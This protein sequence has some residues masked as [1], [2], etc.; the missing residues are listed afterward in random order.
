VAALVREARYRALIQSVPDT[1]LA[2]F[3]QRLR[4]VLA[5][6]AGID[7]HAPGLLPGTP[8]ADLVPPDARS[9]AEAHAREALAGITTTFEY[10]DTGSRRTWSVE[11]GPYRSDGDE[12]GVVWVARD[13]SASRAAEAELA[14]RALHDPLTGLANR[15]LFMDR[16]EQGLARL[17]RRK[18][19]VAVIFIDLDRLKAV[20]DS[21]GHVAGDEV[22]TSMARRMQRVLRPTDTLARFGGDEFVALC[23]EVESAGEAERIA[24]RLGATIAR[25]LVIEDR[26]LVITASMGI[27]LTSNPYTNPAA[28]LRDADAAMYRAKDRG[29]AT[30]AFYNPTMRLHAVD[31]LQIENDLRG[32]LA[33]G[34]LHLLY[35]PQVRMGDYRTIGAEALLRWRHPERG[36]I[37]PAG[38]IALAEETGLMVPIGYWVIEQVCRD[39]GGWPADVEAS[40]NLSANQLAD[41]NLVPRMIAILEQTGVDPCRLCLE[42]TENALFT[43]ADRAARALDELRGLGCRVAIDDFGVGFSSLYHLRQLPDI[44]VL[45]LDRAFVSELGHNDRDAAIVASVILLTN[46]LGMEAL[47][48]GVETEA[49][50]DHLRT[51]GCD[52]GQGFWFGTPGPVEDL[53]ERLAAEAGA[54]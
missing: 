40:I 11:V 28:L 31:R 17:T 35:Q 36:V 41:E 53:T 38:F 33:G 25:P 1:I 47:G 19:Q 10:R 43:E 8:L 30:L 22:I 54:V 14:H 46:S 52:Y 26:E 6:G 2:L 3:D 12:P 39:V 15:Q 34:E 27:A 21:L 23:D 4:L 7:E 48:E 50:A 20:N 29:R 32:A 16:L 44:D 51:M 5:E 18:S 37:E 13:V 45:K 9:E 49:Q 42:V 24:R